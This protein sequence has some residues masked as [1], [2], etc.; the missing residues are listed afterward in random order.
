MQSNSGKISS[1]ARS[2]FCLSFTLLSTT[3]Q[4]AGLTKAQGILRTFENELKMIVPI[5]AIIA[6]VLLAVGY[7]MKTVEKDTFIRWAMGIIIAGSAG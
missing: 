4:A 2:L 5:V 1:L 3:A 7:A 6:L